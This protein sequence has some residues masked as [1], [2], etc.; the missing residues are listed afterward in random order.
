[1][2]RRSQ[3]SPNWSSSC[4]NELHTTLPADE[5]QDQQS[6]YDASNQP[7]NE[8]PVH[9]ASLIYANNFEASLS[10]GSGVSAMGGP[11]GDAGSFSIRADSD[12]AAP[13]SRPG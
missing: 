9:A 3:R 13:G 12:K 1:M 2:G 10:V 11:D 7:I 5:Q 6:D 8:I 4:Q